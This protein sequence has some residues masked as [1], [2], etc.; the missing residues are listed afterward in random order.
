MID[1]ISMLIVFVPF[2]V[3]MLLANVAEKDRVAEK[4]DSFVVFL[5]YGFPAA[6]YLLLFGL[7]IVIQLIG[8][9]QTTSGTD[10]GAIYAEMGMDADTVNSLLETLPVI[11]FGLWFP[12]LVGLVLLLAPVRRLAA[13]VLPIDPQSHVHAIALSFI[14][15]VLMNMLVTLA[16]GIDVLAEASQEGSAGAEAR[17]Y[18]QLWSQQILTAVLA[19]VGVGWGTRRNFPAVLQ[20]LKIT[21]PTGR[22]AAIGLGFA[23]VLVPIVAGF[24]A[25]GSLLGLG[26]PD[27]DAL[28]EALLGP[29]FTSIPGILTLGLAAAIGEET[30]FR[31]AVQPR[32][33]RILTAI[34]FALLHSTYGVSLAFIAVFVLG[35][36]LGWIR[37]RY[38]TTVSMVTHA[39][40]NMTLGFIAYFAISSGLF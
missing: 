8:V 35:Y 12:A 5:A 3:I 18:I 23:F 7:G 1:I 34:L 16:I 11:G 27:V 28:T 13:R 25:I 36:V 30:L 29:L 26:N 22:E 15:V 37:D 40:Y 2:I 4:R 39:A 20:R 14:S 38:S 21:R 19:M 33:G 9:L 10:M 24:E 32:F 17:I 31:G 6:L